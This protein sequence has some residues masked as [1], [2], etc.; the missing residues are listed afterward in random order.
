MFEYRSYKNFD[1]TL[2]NEDLGNGLWHVVENENNIHDALLTWNKL[3]LEVANDHAPVKSRREN[4]T[5]IAWMNR[6]ISDSMRERDWSHRKARKSNSVRHW[7]T[8]RKLRNK[9]NRLVKSAKTKYYCDLIEE[10][11]GNHPKMWKAVNEV[12][13]R[14]S[15][16]ENVQCIISDG[17]QHTTPKS[18]ASAF[19]SFFASIGWRL[20][21]KINGRLLRSSANM[22]TPSIIRLLN[23]SIRTGKF[24]KL[25]KCSKISA[26]FKS[27]DRTNASNYRPISILPTLNKILEKAVHSQ[28]YQYLVTNNLLTR[29]Q[30]GFRKG[31][32]TVSALTSFADEVLLNMEQGNICGAVFLDLTKAFDTV[33]HGI[34][35][36]KLSEIGLCE[37][38]LQWFRTYSY[39]RE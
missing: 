34:P 37:N 33:D 18:I 5:P 35:L 24:P 28:L 26:L 23:L 6:K 12:C 15:T 25:W 36:R 14:N 32:S 3:F 16:S 13:N 19:N 8:Y 10:A 22:I 21:D 20:A 39:M 9:V 30:F 4:G 1:A 38:S 29:K 11:E 2:F 7:N 31:F 27:G 17:I